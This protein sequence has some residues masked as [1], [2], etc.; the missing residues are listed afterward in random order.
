[1]SSKKSNTLRF[2]VGSPGDIKSWIWRMWV[3]GDDVYL[4]A[5]N[6]LKAFKVSLH[7]SNIWRVAF[8]EELRRDNPETDRV[9]I[10][11]QRPE[12]FA[13]GWTPSIGILISSI[14]AKRPFKKRT[15]EDTRIQWFS[16]PTKGRKFIFKILFSKSGTSEI[17]FKKVTIAGD[18]L[19]GKLM[20][21][22]GEAVW[23][24]LREDDLT[25]V[26]TA[27]IEDVMQKTKI[28]LKPGSSEDSLFDS[29]A[30][31]VVSDDIPSI[32]N[33]PT[34]LDIALGKENLDI[35]ISI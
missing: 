6:A 16:S 22:S 18:K 8:V 13:P 31:L 32:L 9:I 19:V 23:L 20:K 29:R 14:D 26:E 24:V 17:D 10:K 25:L 21:K 30:L 4:G 2:A 35:P 33:Q 11:W 1:M 5:R 28:H 12:E 15:I 3:N 34:I 27:K 7:R